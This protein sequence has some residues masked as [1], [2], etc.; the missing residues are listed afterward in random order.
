MAAECTQRCPFRGRRARSDFRSSARMT[1][2]S[3]A[4]VSICTAPVFRVK[5][6]A[7]R[8]DMRYRADW[9]IR[10]A[11]VSVQ[12]MWEVR[13]QCCWKRYIQ[14]PS[15]EPG[16][17]NVI[18]LRP[19]GITPPKFPG[20]RPYSWGQRMM[21]FDRIASEWSGAGVRIEIIGSGC[22]NTAPATASHRPGSR[23]DPRQ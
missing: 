5:P 3:R 19:L 12:C 2:R 9:S 17:V 8:L 4:P 11:P 14:N 20:E 15:L 13:R 23:S 22:D 21:K 7:I 1:D 16:E 10:T 18:R 6:S